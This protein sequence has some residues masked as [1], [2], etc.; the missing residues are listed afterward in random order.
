[1]FTVWSEIRFMLT[2][3]VTNAAA[4][5]EHLTVNTVEW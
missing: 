2:F 3:R 4:V 5:S 1:M